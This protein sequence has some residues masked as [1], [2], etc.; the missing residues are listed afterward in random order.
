MQVPGLALCTLCALKQA[1]RAMFMKLTV[2]VTKTGHRR[3]RSLG[4][5][6]RFLFEGLGEWGKV[7]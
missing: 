2:S 3:E 4:R 6:W 7:S 1:G 5:G